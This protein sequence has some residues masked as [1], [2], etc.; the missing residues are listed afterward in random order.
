M[1]DDYEPALEH[2]TSSID[3]ADDSIVGDGEGAPVEA[4]EVVRDRGVKDTTRKLFAEAAKKLKPQ[5]DAGEGDELEP[6]IT[7][8]PPVAAAAAPEASATSGTSP[9][10]A[11]AAPAPDPVAQTVD[12]RAAQ[13]LELDRKAFD[14]ERKAFESQRAEWDAKFNIREKY[15]EDP[16]GAIVALVKEWTGATSDDE[17]K[18]EVADLVSL[19][20][21]SSLGAALPEHLKIRIDSKRALRQV[22]TYKADQAKR[23]AEAAKKAEAER[24]QQQ[25]RAAIQT[26]NR[27][28]AS[29]S[30]AKKYPHLA[31]E[32]DPGGIVWDVIKTQ[33]ARTGVEPAW[34]EMA[35]LAD[36]HFK[37]KNEAWAA[38]RRHL[39]APAAQKA[40]VVASEPQGDPQSRRS[41]TLTNKTAAP[42]APAVDSDDME[43]DRDAHRRRSLANLRGR[44]KESTT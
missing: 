34:E 29:E 40:P 26:L 22:K 19:L 30:L 18:D 12:T 4:R 7:D 20:S 14:D 5:L 37:K 10:P 13:Q 8:D 42:V 35:A 3:A 17:V 38:K 23:D 16:A 11:A 44:M 39:L 27:E 24:Q 31:A 32:D 28:L 33:F 21:S 2:D 25:E 15:A 9:Q 36:A 1:S 43:I 41:S 6:A